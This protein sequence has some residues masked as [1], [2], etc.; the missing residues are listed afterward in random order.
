L[1]QAFS[2]QA[3]V[4]QPGELIVQGLMLQ[5]RLGASPLFVGPLQFVQHLV[6]SVA[7][8]GDLIVSRDRHPCRKVVL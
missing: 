3:A 6:E 5:A 7:E 2:Q 8:F 4:G 1:C